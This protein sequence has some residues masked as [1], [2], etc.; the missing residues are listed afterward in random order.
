M[1]QL[2]KIQEPS[3]NL[4]MSHLAIDKLKIELI[5]FKT[6]NLLDHS[7]IFTFPFICVIIFANSSRPV[8]SPSRYFNIF[9]NQLLK[10]AGIKKGF[11]PQYLFF[12]F[13]LEIIDCLLSSIENNVKFLHRNQLDSTICD[14][15][16]Q[17]SLPFRNQSLDADIQDCYLNWLKGPKNKLNCPNICN[18]AN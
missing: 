7:A 11:S 5:Q 17:F 8:P 15:F 2:I 9:I 3:Q 1:C 16:R 18:P 13:M 6:I 12:A 10:E 4:N 14:A